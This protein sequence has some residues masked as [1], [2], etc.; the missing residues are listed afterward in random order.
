MA[1]SLATPP[2]RVAM[3]LG[4]SRPPRRGGLC[5]PRVRMREALRCNCCAVTAEEILNVQDV[6]A[7]VT[8]NRRGQLFHAA[9][10]QAMP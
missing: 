10:Y 4:V 2:A 9:R 8:A 3:R 1:T 7:I 5:Q 6:A